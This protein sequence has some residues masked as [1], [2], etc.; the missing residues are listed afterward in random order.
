M[1]SKEYQTYIISQKWR[2]KSSKCQAMT[3]KRC[4]LFPWLRSRHA[5][6]LTYKNLE[7]EIPVRDIVPLSKAAHW[8]VHLPILWR[9]CNKVSP[10]RVLVN[11]VLRSLFVFWIVINFLLGG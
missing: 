2:S 1:R 11:L 4:V 9:F 7:H 5:H 10:V 3:G 8:I 6:H